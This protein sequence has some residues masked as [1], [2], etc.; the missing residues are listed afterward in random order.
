MLPSNIPPNPFQRGVP[1]DTAGTVISP[2]LSPQHNQRQS[3]IVLTPLTAT[4]SSRIM[5][6]IP[7][8]VQDEWDKAL[9]YYWATLCEDIRLSTIMNN[10]SE[11]QHRITE[12]NYQNNKLP[13]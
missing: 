11:I 4:Y 12:K 9:T 13:A 2:R 3:S 8:D 1:T 5:T 6:T 7:L 10:E